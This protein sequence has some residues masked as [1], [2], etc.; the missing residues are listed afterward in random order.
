[1][2]GTAG[3][4]RP[5]ERAA[6]LLA[7]LG[8]LSAVVASSEERLDTIGGRG[9]GRALRAAFALVRRLAAI[10]LDRRPIIGT[11]EALLAYLRVAIGHAQRE[12]MRVLYLDAAHRLIRD[13]PTSRG[14][15]ARLA[16]YPREIVRRA[17]ELSASGLIL[18][19]NH[20]SGDPTPS[21]ADVAATREIV[22]LAR[23]FDIDVHDHL[24]VARTGHAS[25][26]AL[27]LI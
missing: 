2:L 6:A 19:H 5:A 26:R 24:V 20:P 1:M 22:Q 11:S 23:S 13:E 21:A 16:I 4:D 3:L 14:T 8:G 12:E 15:V 7:E 18:A 25:M 10:E 17:L 9:V 27:K